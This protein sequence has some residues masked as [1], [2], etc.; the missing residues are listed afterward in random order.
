MHYVAA[1]WLSVLTVRDCF[2]KAGFGSSADCN[3]EDS[4]D[5]PVDDE[6]WG[7]LEAVSYTHL[8]VYKRQPC[9]LYCDVLPL[10]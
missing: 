10:L 9:M 3:N 2:H 8:D 1:T 4:C 7:K 5:V 6:E